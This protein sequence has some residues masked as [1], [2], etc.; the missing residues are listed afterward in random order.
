MP[1]S[2][3]TR[4]VEAKEMEKGRINE[5]RTVLLMGSRAALQLGS[6]TV[7]NANSE[8]MTAGRR[9]SGERGR[10]GGSGDQ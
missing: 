9:D 4:K 2:A 7:I 6:G 10:K 1:D 3:P 5:T 8:G